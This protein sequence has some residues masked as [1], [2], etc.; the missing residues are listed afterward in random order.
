MKPVIDARLRKVET[1][2]LL[3]KYKVVDKQLTAKQKKSLELAVDRLMAKPEL[4][5]QLV[6]PGV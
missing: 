5:W 4:A 6:H 3:A 2:R 1:A